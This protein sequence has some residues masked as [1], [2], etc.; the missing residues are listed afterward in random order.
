MINPSTVCSFTRSS[1][2]TAHITFVIREMTK[3]C[4]QYS[5]M[6]SALPWLLQ[7]LSICRVY[8]CIYR[9]TARKGDV[10]TGLQPL[11]TRQKLLRTTFRCSISA[12]L[13][14]C[15]LCP[16]DAREHLDLDQHG[17]QQSLLWSWS[18]ILSPESFSLCISQQLPA[19]KWEGME[20]Q[21]LPRVRRKEHK[22]GKGR[23]QMSSMSPHSSSPACCDEPPWHMLTPALKGA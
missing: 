7:N 22:G 1:C 16:L 6:S 21:N 15:F 17:A 5:Q 14:C 2:A 9:S 20:I 10:T 11:L 18:A 8:P 19:G 4:S 12:A 23:E 13:D 3:M